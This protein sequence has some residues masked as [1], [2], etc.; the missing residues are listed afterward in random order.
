[1][2]MDTV[3]AIDE[4]VFFAPSSP[5]PDRAQVE[6]EIGTRSTSHQP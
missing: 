1:M 4:T 5:C 2:D 3:H 6:V